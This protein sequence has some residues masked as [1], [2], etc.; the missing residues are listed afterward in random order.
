VPYREALASAFDAAARHAA[1]GKPWLIEGR[2]RV[3]TVAGPS[4]ASLD[5]TRRRVERAH[6]DALERASL[7]EYRA[8][9]TGDPSTAQAYLDSLADV[10]GSAAELW[11]LCALGAVATRVSTE[12]RREDRAVEIER[13]TAQL[14]GM[15]S[16]DAEYSKA[17][18]QRR[19][20]HAARAAIAPLP[21]AAV[22]LVQRA[23]SVKDDTRDAIARRNRVRKT[24]ARV[25][26]RIK[27]ANKVLPA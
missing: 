8:L 18:S 12:R 19:A 15:K 17:C 27:R 21:E 5:E 22:Y 24:N 11:A 20:A 26:R 16:A 4:Y 25:I 23:P 13:L 14:S 3:T 2:Q 6:R 1:R 10:D 7:L 9:V